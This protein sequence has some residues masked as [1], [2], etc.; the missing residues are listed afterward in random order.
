MPTPVFTWFPDAET[1]ESI[2]PKVNLT[3]FGDGYEQR[4]SVGINNKPAKWSMKFTRGPE[5]AL[6]IRT[7]LSAR[8]GVE[9]FEWTNPF[10]E[11]GKYVCRKWSLSRSAGTVTVTCEF[12]QVFEY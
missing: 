5:E 6:A 4:T 8:G 10:E 1:Q 2:E 9:A 3:K 7:F 11:L 12:E